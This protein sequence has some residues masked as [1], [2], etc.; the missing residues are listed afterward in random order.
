MTPFEIAL[1]IRSRPDDSEP[2]RDFVFRTMAQERMSD[3]RTA[4]E[5]LVGWE[6]G[7][8]DVRT[9][10]NI[11]GQVGGADE[12]IGALIEHKRGLA[13]DPALETVLARRWRCPHCKQLSTIDKIKLPVGDAACLPGCPA[14]GEEGI[15]PVDTEARLDV[16]D[17]GKSGLRPI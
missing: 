3:F 1:A 2:V 5:L 10:F 12:T 8:D 11:L 14:C 13:Y 9:I 15:A 4:L 17:G 6:R 16:R 7:D